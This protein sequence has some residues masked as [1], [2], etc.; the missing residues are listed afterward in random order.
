MGENASEIF[1]RAVPRS[2]IAAVAVLALAGAAPAFA[3]QQPPQG[4]AQPP[5]GQKKASA[6]DAT[7]AKDAQQPVRIPAVVLAGLLTGTP[8]SLLALKQYLAAVGASPDDVAKRAL[9]VVQQLKDAGIVRD[10]ALIISAAERVSQAVK[11]TL[12]S[13]KVVQLKIDRDFRPPA[14]VMAFDFAPADAKTHSGFRRVLPNDP[15]L[16]GRQMQAIRRPGEEAD[17]LGDGVTGVERISVDMPDGE[18]RVTLMTESTGDAT[19]SLAPFGEKIVANGKSIG[20]SQA[21]PDNWLKQSVLSTKGLGGFQT[22]TERQGGAVTVTVRVTGGKLNL[23][24]DMGGGDSLKT[25]L[26]GMIVEPANRPSVFN[27]LPEMRSALFTPPETQTRY[28]SQIASSIADLLERT[29]PNAGPETDDIS[30]PVQTVQR[31]SPG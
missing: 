3:Q 23:G 18:Y 7:G 8:E 26:T 17:I 22:A 4:Q 13:L 21:T 25:Y 20:V 12:S 11:E 14:G 24:F 28:E 2:L 9:E 10:P 15:M 30:K 31:A 29:T 16:A 27:A 1:T 6:K 5:A 19:T